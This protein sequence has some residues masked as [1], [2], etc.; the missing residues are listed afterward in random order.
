[1]GLFMKV[2]GLTLATL[3]T[4]QAH[5]SKAF[6]VECADFIREVPLTFELEDDYGCCRMENAPYYG[7]YPRES[8]PYR[9]RDGREVC[10]CRGDG[11]VDREFA[12]SQ[13]K[14][15]SGTF[16]GSHVYHSSSVVTKL[17]F[18]DPL[19]IA[20][21]IRVFQ[22]DKLF[23]EIPINEKGEVTVIVKEYH[24]DR[25]LAW[26]ARLLEGKVNG[27]S[28]RYDG[29]GN[30]V[31]FS[32]EDKPVFEGDRDRCGFNGRPSA[33]ELKSDQRRRIL[34]HLKG[35]LTAEESFSRNGEREV[36][37]YPAGDRNTVQVESF[38][39]N[40]K[41]RSRY[42]KKKE[43]LD[44]QFV[45]FYDNGTTAEEGRAEKG[46]ITEL[47]RF[48]M[49]GG[50]KVEASLSSDPSVCAVRLFSSHGELQVDGSFK[51]RYGALDWKVPHGRLR[52]Y[53]E[54]GT[55]CRDGNYTDGVPTGTHTFYQEGGKKTEVVFD[56]GKAKR[57]R[58]YAAGG[59]VKESDIFD[60]GSIRNLLRRSGN[61]F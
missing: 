25:R 23:C 8:I 21:P 6:A 31:S 51:T 29:G 32:C 60:D 40:G 46:K 38:F 3:L 24:S 58:E 16:Y 26:Q 17:E 52:S 19:K 37:R 55:L 42:T 5:G 56:K 7:E 45:E 27:A 14:R 10:S 43:S 33:V 4:L 20:N 22:D 36:K 61:Y 48:Y 18:R 30:L 53:D 12:W 15:I 2:M 44:G 59:A 39:K 57:L 41:L 54:D 13:G 50:K 49:N 1:M 34:T 28:V 11:R 35:K 47:K 9:L